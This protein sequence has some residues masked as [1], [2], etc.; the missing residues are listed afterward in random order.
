MP[1]LCESHNGHDINIKQ[2]SRILALSRT[3]FSP[4]P[5]SALLIIVSVAPE[6]KPY[7]S[8]SS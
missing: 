4:P 7:S 1:R 3:P 2:K 8:F 5:F 6:L